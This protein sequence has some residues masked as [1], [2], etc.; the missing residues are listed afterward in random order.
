MCRGETTP[1]LYS[2][3]Y[4]TME[5]YYETTKNYAVVRGAPNQPIEL[6]GFYN[7][8][9]IANMEARTMALQKPNNTSCFYEVMRVS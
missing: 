2:I 4:N 7:S 3:R 8:L 9:R 5:N 6:V 1:I